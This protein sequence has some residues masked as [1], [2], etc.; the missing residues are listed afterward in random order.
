MATPVGEMSM[1]RINEFG[2]VIGPD[3]HGWEPPEFP[4]PRELEGKSVQLEPLDRGRHAEAL[5]T[6]YRHASDSIWTYMTVGPFH[7]AVALGDLIDTLVAYPDWRPFAIVVEGTPLGFLSYLRID[8]RNGVIEIGS[9]VFSPPLQRTKPA[10]EAVYLVLKN[11]FDLGYRRCEWKCDD[12]NEPSRVAAVRLGF[13]YEG[14]FRKA[15]H[16]KARSRDTAWYSITDD[17]WPAVDRA[18]QLWLSDD[19]FDPDGR[20]RQ[21]LR[22]LRGGG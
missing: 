7:S 12:L 1:P 16:Y 13:R 4:P 14:T 20:Q 2:Q 21:S 18:F 15:T 19:N 3:L 11:A 17:E 9:I 5:F 10:T 22:A 6:A 8:P